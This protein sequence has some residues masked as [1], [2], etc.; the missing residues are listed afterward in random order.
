MNKQAFLGELQS[1]LS[2]L[3]QN[4]I[5]ERLGFYSEMIDDRIEEG[6]EEEKAV[7]DI[8]SI[9]EIVTQ[10]LADYPLSK[11]VKEKVKP[12]RSLRAWEIVLLIVG[13]PIW[14]SLLIAAAAVIFSLYITLWALLI[15]L[16]AIELSF[17][18]C[19]LAGVVS[20]VA[21]AVHGQPAPGFAMLGMG[22]LFTGLTIF[23]FFGCVAASKGIIILTKKIA[24]GI[25]SLFIGKGDK[26][27]QNS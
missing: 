27:E 13:S 23:L 19:A 24:L 18:A 7:A 22:I 12:K 1:R 2:G 26:N 6:V 5:N 3:P 17:A 4:D 16:W 15:S 14:L 10:I 9:D 20:S 8:G 21:L 25:K 11:L